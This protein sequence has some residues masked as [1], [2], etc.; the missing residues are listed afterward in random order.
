[1]QKG[2]DMTFTYGALASALSRRIALAQRSAEQQRQWFGG[3][4]GQ[5][6]HNGNAEMREHPSSDEPVKEVVTILPD[7]NTVFLAVHDIVKD[8]VFC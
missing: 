4:E 5:R 7:A 8:I 6:D 3:L 2:L 1:M